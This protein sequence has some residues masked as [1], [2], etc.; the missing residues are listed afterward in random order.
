MYSSSC[1]IPYIKKEITV[2]E[3]DYGLK[4]LKTILKCQ[5]FVH[6]GLKTKEIFL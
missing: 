3:E 6:Y 4:I 1:F 5:N 2:V